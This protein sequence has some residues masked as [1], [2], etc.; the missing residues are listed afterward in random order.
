MRI[1]VPL[2]LL[3]ACLVRAIVLFLAA[4]LVN[5]SMFQPGAA[6]DGQ[7]AASEFLPALCSPLLCPCSVAAEMLQSSSL[8]A[9]IARVL[10]EASSGRG[11]GT[12][13]LYACGLASARK[14]LA[15]RGESFVV[16]LLREHTLL[17]TSRNELRPE[18]VYIL[19]SYA[20]ARVTAGLLVILRR[21]APS[22]VDRV[23]RCAPRTT[24]PCQR[25]SDSGT[26]SPR[27]RR[28]DSRTPSP[29]R[30]QSNNDREAP[31]L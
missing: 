23:A 5:I 27:Q 7:A 31:H 3:D 14:T 11:A 25:R 2:T 30:R 6:S 28:S 16:A 20:H 9:G 13:Q 24:P 10:L 12:R 26:P 19:G 22:G 15:P 17:R 18:T 29:R 1:L 21:N 8:P 4:P